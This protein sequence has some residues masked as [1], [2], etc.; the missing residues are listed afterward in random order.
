MRKKLL[1]YSLL[2]LTMLVGVVTSA[3]AE[4]VTLQY[5]GSTTTNMSGKNDATLLGLDETEWL[6]EGDKGQTAQFPG[7]NKDGSIRLYWGNGGSNTFT[8]TSLTGATIDNI[9]IYYVATYAG[10][11]VEVGGQKVNGTALVSVSNAYNYSINSSSFVI[12]NNNSTNAQVRFSKIEI[13]YTAGSGYV[14]PVPVISGETPFSDETT[15]SI[16]V[17]TTG[18]AGFDIRYTTDGTD[19]THNSQQYTQ[20]FTI[21]ETT[22]VKAIAIDAAGGPSRV[23]S[24]TFTKVASYFHLEELQQAATKDK[25]PVIVKFGGGQYEQQVVYVSGNSVYIAEPQTG[26]GIM[27]YQANHGL[28]AGDVLYGP[29]D[30]KLTLYNGMAELMEFDGTNLVKDNQTVTPAV[31]G[32]IGRVGMRNQSTLITLNNVTAASQNAEAKTWLLKDNTGEIQFYDKFNTGVE[33]EKG[34]EYNITGVVLIF[35]GVLQIAPRTAD[36]VVC[37]NAEPEEIVLWESADAPKEVN[38]TSDV[39]IGQEDKKGMALMENL[40]I[41]D[42]FHVYVTGAPAKG[43]DWSAMIGLWTGWWLHCLEGFNAFEQDG[44]TFVHDFVVTGD[45]LPLLKSEGFLVTGCG[46][47]VE[48]VT[49]SHV[50]EG[51]E[52]SIW[53]GNRSLNEGFMIDETHMA[54]FNGLKGVNSGDQFRFTF[55]NNVTGSVWADAGRYGVIFESPTGPTNVWSSSPISKDMAVQMKNN[56]VFVH[57]EGLTANLISV[58]IIPGVYPVDE[59]EDVTLAWNPAQL[60]V[61]MD[62]DFTQPKVTATGAELPADAEYIYWSDNCSVAGWDYENKK[63]VINGVGEATISAVLSIYGYVSNIAELKVVVKE[64]SNLKPIGRWEFKPGIDLS[65]VD[66]WIK[67]EAKEL[68]YYDPDHNFFNLRDKVYYTNKV[69]LN[70]VKLLSQNGAPA[71]DATPVTT[72]SDPSF[73]VEPEKLTVDDTDGGFIIDGSITLSVWKDKYIRI[74]WR[75]ADE[76]NKG[77]LKETAGL[78]VATTPDAAP[79]KAPAR[80]AYV[81]NEGQNYNVSYFKTTVD[82]EVDLQTD[83]AVKIIYIE[84]LET[85]DTGI[86]AI[87]TDEFDVTKPAY[88][89]SGRRVNSDYHGIVIQNG[90]KFNR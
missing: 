31:Q 75:P 65:D 13:S 49:V 18:T 57:G 1:R 45:M 88:D 2:L 5:T 73:T 25:T 24:K 77:K 26:C 80:V 21:T 70:K 3:M 90:R 71:L 56:G 48:K 67:R 16:S 30:C 41:G 84:E 66:K 64:K 34:K 17:E 40:K 37:L 53:L 39:T 27:V 85:I 76:D 82:G 32:S 72:L 54:N 55:A 11:Y 22:T 35:N 19:P 60:E 20:P 62:A 58:E 78:S 47:S 15:V 59:P 7:L 86:N 79:R 28:T 12:G 43:G 9:T 6:V 50:Y 83:G 46:F 81:G 44:P 87:T 42:V 4:T 89:L 52:N 8:V 38:W 74:T 14:V 51:S 63:V 33:L 10:G 23:A 29:V 61:E 68:I 36:D 69:K